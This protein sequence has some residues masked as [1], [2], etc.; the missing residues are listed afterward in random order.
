[1]SELSFAVM[2]VR[3]PGV[4]RDL[5]YGPEDLRWVSNSATL[6][7]GAEDALLVDS[8][9]TREQN[10]ELIAWIS[11]S[12]RRL[13]R[14]YITHGHGDHL[15]GLAQ[16]HD[17]F[18][19]A[20]LVTTPGALA[21]ARVQAGDEYFFSFW[22][23][24]FPGEI[25]TPI[26]LPEALA[27]DRLDVEGH[28]VHIVETGFTDTQNTTSVWVPELGLIVAG[29][30]VYDEAH[31][32]L[33]E[34]SSD[35]RREWV[36][37]LEKLRSLEPSVIVAGHGRPDRTSGVEAIDATVAY[38]HDFERAAASAADANELF[39][40]MMRR[41]GDRINPGSLWGAAKREKG[42]PA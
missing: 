6:I 18:P 2:H 30:V 8:F 32:Y 3:R 33:A 25:E 7:F 36:A 35:T 34:T 16:L 20:E 37:S 17:A 4:T 23:R 42:A 39:D 15:F 26:L 19:D 13:K 10:A 38:L 14:V 11:A 41:Y 5:P 29:D 22:D 12:G 27:G 40:A 21:V 24:L 31:L 1:M 28:P 9:T